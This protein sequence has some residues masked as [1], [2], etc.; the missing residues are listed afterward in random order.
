M[1]RQA[2]NGK[3]RVL[4]ITHRVKVAG[5]WQG[6]HISPTERQRAAAGNEVERGRGRRITTSAPEHTVRSSADNPAKKAAN[7]LL[8]QIIEKQSREINIS[9]KAT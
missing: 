9:E 3:E 2:G 5:R 7:S 8:S 4:V 6:K 1:T